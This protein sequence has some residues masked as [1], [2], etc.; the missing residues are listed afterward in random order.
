MNSEIYNVVIIGNPGVGKTTIVNTLNN[1]Y[2]K[3]DIPESK[4]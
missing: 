2:R 1:I 4:L 3:I